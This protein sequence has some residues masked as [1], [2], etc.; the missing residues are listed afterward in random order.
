MQ[1]YFIA[2]LGRATERKGSEVVLSRYRQKTTKRKQ[3]SGV[4]SRGQY[5]TTQLRLE[6]EVVSFFSSKAT[7]LFYLELHV[8]KKQL[9]SNSN[10]NI[11]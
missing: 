6:E 10:L 5:K 2:K 9:S 7:Q 8:R 1:R 11:Y 3:K 4:V